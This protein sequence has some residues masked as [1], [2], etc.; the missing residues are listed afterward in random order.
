MNDL[1]LYRLLQK[2]Q[3][4]ELSREEEQLLDDWYNGLNHTPTH[5]YSIAAMK[6]RVWSIIQAHTATPALTP[7]SVPRQKPA[8]RRL[9]RYAAAAAILIIATTAAL[10]FV[11]HPKP[12]AAI[13]VALTTIRVP[14]G[15][16]EK[17]TLSD[18]T[19]VWLNGDAVLAY[20]STFDTAR[21]VNLLEG[22]AFFE[23]AADVTKP[24]IVHSQQ[25][26]TQVL[27]T[28]FDIRNYRGHYMVAVATGKV[29]VYYKDKTNTL[30]LSN[31]IAGERLTTNS[32]GEKPIVD[33]LESA[34]C[35]GWTDRAYHLKDVSLSGIAYCM[36]SIYGVSIHIRGAA[37]KK[38]TF[39]TS[40]SSKDKM[41]DILDR[42]SLAGEFHYKMDSPDT[43]TIY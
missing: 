33:S 6:Q 11:P 7:V 22:E 21:N 40:V 26:H 41:K 27:G 8:P 29:K 42:L 17:L 23:V 5:P 35:K 28:S 25:L 43:V 18:G 2:Q 32:A 16:Q 3:A 31:L 12:G 39:T 34:L 24:F 10:Y 4:G 36:E 20:P 38:L 14:H 9:L 1:E 13:P 37:L 15:G 19:T 30:Q